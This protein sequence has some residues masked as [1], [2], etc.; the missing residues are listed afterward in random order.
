MRTNSLRLLEFCKLLYILSSVYL[1]TETETMAT[2]KA[3]KKK[4]VPKT[5][6]KA[7]KKAAKKKR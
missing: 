7:K 4:F 6:K 5:K 3:S 1:D 2:K